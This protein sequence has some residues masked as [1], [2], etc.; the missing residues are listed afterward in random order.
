MYLGPRLVFGGTILV[1]IILGAFLFLAST[2]ASGQDSPV[3]ELT[4][5]Q[6]IVADNQASGQSSSNSVDGSLEACEVSEGFPESI[7]RWCA[8]ITRYAQKHSLSPDLVAALIWQESGGDAQA[9]SKDGAVG[10]MQIMPRDGISASFQCQNGPCFGDRPS[11]DELT[12]P[13]YNLAFGTRMLANLV[14]RHGNLRQAL[15]S[16]GPMNTGYSYA[17]KVLSLYQQ[18]GK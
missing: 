3:A 8:L 9:F 7:R 12:D 11:T 10:L 18:Y 2:G 17:D 13:E 16:Y 4:P 6:I 15:K 14:A 5:Q 1:N